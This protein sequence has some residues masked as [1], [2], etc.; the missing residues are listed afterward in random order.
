MVPASPDG[1]L[2]NMIEATAFITPQGKTVLVIMNRTED[3]AAFEVNFCDSEGKDKK[4][5][6]IYTYKVTDENFERVF[7]CPPRSIQTYIFD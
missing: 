6:K 5:E 1:R 2:G 7:V 3:D 4:A